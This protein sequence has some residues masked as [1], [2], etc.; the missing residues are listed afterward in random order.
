MHLV[1]RPELV[2]EPWFASGRQRAEH[3]DELDDAVGGW[4][5]QRN[6]DEV[7]EAFEKAQAAVAPIYTAADVLEDPQFRALGSIVTDRRRRAGPDPVP[8]RAV[9][10]VGDPGPG[11]DVGPAAGPAHRGGARPLRRRRGTAGAAA[12]GGCGVTAP[13]TALGRARSWLYVPAHRPD[14]R[15][16]GADRRRRRG[17][18]RPRGRGARRTPRTTARAAA[19]A[20]LEAPR[21]VPVWVRMNTVD[22]PWARADADALASARPDGVRVPKAADA[23]AVAELAAAARRAGAPAAGVGAGC[24][25]RVRAGPVPPAGR[26]SVTRRGR[27]APPTCM[28]ATPRRCGWARQRVVVANRAAGLAEPSGRGLDRPRRPRRPR[29][30]QHRRP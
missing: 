27:P 10:A 28:S 3:A 7:I 8:E 6:R 4:I 1:G 17:G 18:A 21:A 22:S 26:R 23:A 29:R 16:Q 11:P 19:V 25:E 2:D 12:R 5:A 15:R 20:A 24:R 14:L 30:R 9:P 13:A